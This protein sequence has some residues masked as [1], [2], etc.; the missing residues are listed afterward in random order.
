MKKELVEIGFSQVDFYAN[1]AGHPYS[2]NSET[3]AFVATKGGAD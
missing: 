3:V 1:V 2:A